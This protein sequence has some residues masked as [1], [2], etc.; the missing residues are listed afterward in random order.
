V[1]GGLPAP[2]FAVFRNFVILS[3]YARGSFGPLPALAAAWETPKIGN[4]KVNF[5]FST[6]RV[7]QKPVSKSLIKS[8]KVSKRL[9]P[10]SSCHNVLV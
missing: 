6:P 10:L 5:W 9:I 8:Q 4:E 3:G 7:H 2:L 1:F